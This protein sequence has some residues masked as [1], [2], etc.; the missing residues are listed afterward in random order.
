MDPEQPREA[1]GTTPGHNKGRAERD[2]PTRHHLVDRG[3][4]AG[5]EDRIR[6]QR[7]AGHVLELVSE[8]AAPLSLQEALV[9]DD[10]ARAVTGD[11][12]Q[13]CR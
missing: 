2:Q 7:T 4:L 5:G 1:P 3:L 8:G 9:E 13:V 11:A 12:G 6:R 10:D